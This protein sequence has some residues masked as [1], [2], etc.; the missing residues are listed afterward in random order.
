MGSERSEKNSIKTS[1]ATQRT[2]GNSYVPIDLYF[3]GSGRAALNF[4]Y[5]KFSKVLPKFSVQP[6]PGC[7]RKAEDKVRKS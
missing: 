3:K 4:F 5:G 2:E 6:R 1:K 7:L